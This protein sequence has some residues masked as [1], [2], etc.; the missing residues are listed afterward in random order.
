MNTQTIRVPIK[1]WYGDEE[2][3]LAFAESWEVEECRMRGHDTPVLSDDQLREALRHP[4]GTQTLREMA[5]GR[6]EVV[7]LF[8]DLTRP[9]PVGR[10][11]R[12]EVDIA[13]WPD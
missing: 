2:M 10:K 9:P 1:A 6:K 5:Q 4:M 11:A 8:D 7:I 3:E 12:V 13:D